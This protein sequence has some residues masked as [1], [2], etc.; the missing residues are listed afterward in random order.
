MADFWKT[1]QHE[2]GEEGELNRTSSGE[3]DGGDDIVAGLNVKINMISFC[4]EEEDGQ[5]KKEKILVAHL[6]ETHLGANYSDGQ[7]KNMKMGFVRIDCQDMTTRRDDV[8]T[9]QCGEKEGNA[10]TIEMTPGA[11]VDIEGVECD[12]DTQLDIEIHAPIVVVYRKY[13]VKAVVD[14]FCRTSHAALVQVNHILSPKLTTLT[15]EF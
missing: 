7:V 3:G 14:F 2:G 5:R 9:F 12:L 15:H 13:L 10:C 11:S 6:S 4:L 1:G 8:Y